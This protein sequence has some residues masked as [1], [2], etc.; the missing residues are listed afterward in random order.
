MEFFSFPPNSLKFLS[1]AG[2]Q[3]FGF[4]GTFKISL[5]LPGP[6]KE[7]QLLAGCGGDNSLAN[8]SPV[9]LRGRGFGSDPGEHPGFLVGP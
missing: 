9:S 8:F 2:A 1:C 4:L 3:A 7:H 6:T 5:D